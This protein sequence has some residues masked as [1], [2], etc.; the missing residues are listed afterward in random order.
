[1]IIFLYILIGLWLAKGLFE[2]TRSLVLIVYG[3]CCGLV[4]LSCY[5]AASMLDVLAWLW[6]SARWIK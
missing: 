6:R 1:M 2:V 5:A 4:A 3:L